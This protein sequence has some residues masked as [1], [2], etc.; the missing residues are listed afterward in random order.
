MELSSK[1][2]IVF[3]YSNFL[4]RGSSLRNAEFAIGIAIYTG[5]DTRIM[6]NSVKS[7]I[8]TSY[9]ERMMGYQLLF[10]FFI[11]CI[12]CIIASSYVVWWNIK[13]DVSTNSYLAFYPAGSSPPE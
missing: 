3:D 11:E 13:F 4:L 8:K 10:V 1:D 6:Q 9:L 2:K 7:R 5:P 12:L